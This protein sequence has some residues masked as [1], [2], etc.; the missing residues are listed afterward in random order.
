MW[1][2]PEPIPENPK[3]KDLVCFFNER[4]TL[5]VDGVEEPAPDT[6]WITSAS[7]LGSGQPA[8]TA[9]SGTADM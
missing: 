4:V 2:Y 6:P 5:I 1:S 9:G 3:I 8:A 7:G